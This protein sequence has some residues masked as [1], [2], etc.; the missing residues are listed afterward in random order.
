MKL[1]YVF[2]IVT[3]IIK[4]KVTIKVTIIIK[5]IKI[6]YHFKRAIFKT[7]I[8][9]M[10]TRFRWM[11]QTWRTR[12][13]WRT[14]WIRWIRRIQRIWRIRQIQRIRGINSLKGFSVLFTLLLKVLY[15]LVSYPLSYTCLKRERQI[16]RKK[17]LI[18]RYL[19]CGVLGE[20]VF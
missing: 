6:K 11:R 14:H 10:Q 15:L 1:N 7:L 18:P 9:R 19:Q 16:S 20:C 2:I 3:I 17:R 4:V 5:S 8:R 13:I 12:R